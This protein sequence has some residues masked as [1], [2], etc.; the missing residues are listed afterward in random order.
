[1]ISGCESHARMCSC[2]RGT[3]EGGMDEYGGIEPRD[4]TDEEDEK[5][6]VETDEADEKDLERVR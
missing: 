1:M 6:A 2:R 4:S 5:D 3:C